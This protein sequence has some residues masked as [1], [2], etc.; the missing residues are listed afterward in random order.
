MIIDFLEDESLLDYWNP[1]IFRFKTNAKNFKINMEISNKVKK[2]YPQ[3]G[4]T[5]IEG[6]LIMFRLKG[7]KSWYN[8]DAYS[9]KPLFN[10]NMARII[11][12]D[13]EYE[14]LIYGPM[15]S[16]LELFN[17]EIP[18]QYYAERIDMKFDR[19]I[20]VLGGLQSLGVGCTTIGV[21]FSS[22]LAREFET[23]LY[24]IA[25]DDVNHLEKIHNFFKDNH[26]IP[27]ADIGILELGYFSQNDD[28][29]NNHLLDVINI[30]K[31]FY[32]KIICWF[33]LPNFQKSKKENIYG[34]LKE[35]IES[36][37]IIFKDFSYLHDDEYYSDMCTFSNKYINDSGN[38]IIYKEFKKSILEI[39]GWSI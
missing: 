6:V 27:H 28:D 37:K 20:A 7:K 9:R 18:D 26:N 32:D 39:M 21:M 10:V 31:T 3:L 4:I 5:A 29:V 14:V 8:F 2:D 24:K 23:E 12:D 25:F 22:I 36:G 16:S 38:I 11:N 17:V 1:Y 33:T 13:S 30:M 35:D 34:V 15:L 19:K